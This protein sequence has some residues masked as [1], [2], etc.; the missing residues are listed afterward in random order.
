MN[1]YNRRS[2]R[3]KIAR[4]MAGRYGTDRL[5]FFLLF[6]CSSAIIVNIFLGSF[7][8]SVVEFL[9]IGYAIFRVLSRNVYKRQ[10]EN[11]FFLKLT[12]RP[13]DFFNLQKCKMRDRKTHAFRRCPSCKNQLRLP[14]T[15]GRHTVVCPV[16]KN[17]FDTKI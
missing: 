9:L 8:L 15:K 3:E 6:L 14:K 10:K 11:E 4:F 7:L 5:Y 12:K 1:N 2:F 17:R 16:C 13:R